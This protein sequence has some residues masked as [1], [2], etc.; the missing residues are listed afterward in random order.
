VVQMG[1]QN[2]IRYHLALCLLAFISLGW[3]ILLQQKPLPFALTLL[4]FGFIGVHLGRVYRSKNP[5]ELDPELKK[6]A[7]STFFI[8]LILYLVNDYFL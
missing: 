6:L 4:P 8:A 2:G 3:F 1:Y 7:L 5:S